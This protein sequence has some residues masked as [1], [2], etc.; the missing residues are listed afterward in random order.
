MVWS[1]AARASMLSRVAASRQETGLEAQRHQHLAA[2]DGL[3]GLAA[4]I[5]VVRHSDWII[6]HQLAPGGHLAVDFFFLLSGFVLSLA[7]HRWV[8]EQLG[9]RRAMATRLIRLWPMYA[10]GTAIGV[11]AEHQRLLTGDAFAAKAFSKVVAG[12]LFLPSYSKYGDIDV[13]P[14]DVPAWSL[15]YELLANALFIALVFTRR[16]RPMHVI[17]LACGFGVIVLAVLRNTL[18]GGSNIRT[19][20]VGLVRVGFSFFLGVIISEVW[21][22]RSGP[23]R[24]PQ[25]VMAPICLAFVAVIFRGVGALPELFSVLVLFPVI[26]WISASTSLTGP[27]RTLARWSGHLSYP[28]YALHSPVFNVTSRLFGWRVGADWGQR[29]QWLLV[30]ASLV[31]VCIWLDASVQPRIRRALVLSRRAG[32]ASR[33]GLA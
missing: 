31:P 4:V 21:A 13:F 25:I 19:F 7:A 15:F 28:L 20:P 12:F 30:L 32:G 9:W 18:D 24:I 11:A 22:R 5:V 10:L 23:G 6:G 26:V 2:L 3:R 1:S 14:Y 16:V 8:S 33:R 17:A 29:V 27:A